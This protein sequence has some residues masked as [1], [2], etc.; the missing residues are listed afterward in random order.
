MT[1]RIEEITLTYVAVRL[2]DNT[3]L[4]L[5][6]T[7]F[8][9]TPFQNWTHKGARVSGVVEIAVDGHAPLDA[10]LGALRE[11]LGRQNY[12]AALPGGQ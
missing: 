1:G 3:T 9:T 11:E 7:Y 2:R 12:P 10:L 4:I 5:P 8:T 6:C